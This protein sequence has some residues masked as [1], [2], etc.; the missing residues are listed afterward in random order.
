[1]LFRIELLFYL[2]VERV[3]FFLRINIIDKLHRCA[4]PVK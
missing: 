2:E 1:V 4:R 3:H